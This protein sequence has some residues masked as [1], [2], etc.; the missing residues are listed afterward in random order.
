MGAGFGGVRF[1]HAGFEA[2]VDTI[3]VVHAGSQ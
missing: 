2:P 1:L 3:G